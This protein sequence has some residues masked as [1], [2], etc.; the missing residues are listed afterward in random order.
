MMNSRIREF[1]G[2]L[3]V[4]VLSVEAGVRPADVEKLL[5]EL[6][7]TAGRLTEEDVAGRLNLPR[8]SVSLLDYGRVVGGAGPAGDG[9]RSIWETLV[10]DFLSGRKRDLGHADLVALA[11]IMDE[12]GVFASQVAAALGEDPDPAAMAGVGDLLRH[13][14]AFLVDTLGIDPREALATVKRCLLELPGKIGLGVAEVGLGEG[15]TART[16]TET[17]RSFSLEDTARF[18]ASTLDAGTSARR[19]LTNVLQLISLDDSARRDILPMLRQRMEQQVEGGLSEEKWRQIQRFMSPSSERYVSDSYGRLLDLAVTAEDGEGPIDGDDGERSE[20]LTSL[21]PDSV[22]EDLFWLLIEDARITLDDRLFEVLR[23]EVGG[24]LGGFVAEGLTAPAASG[25]R[26][27]RQAVEGDD[28]HP[29]RRSALA[30]LAAESLTPG[31]LEKLLEKMPGGDSGAAEGEVR[32]ILLAAPAA[33]AAVGVSVLAAADDETLPRFL[34]EVLAD[35]GAP[36]AAEALRLLPEAR[37]PGLRRLLKLLGAVGEAAAVPRLAPLLRHGDQ[38]VRLDA[39][40]ALVSIDAAA[41]PDL[42]MGVVDDGDD[43]MVELIAAYLAARGDQA[44]IVGRLLARA[45]KTGLF[46]G[47]DATA[48]SA[49]A[50]LGTIGAQEAVPLLRKLLLR[51]RPLMPSAR[52]HD[53]ALAAVAALGSIAGPEAESALRDGARKGAKQVARACSLALKRRGGGSR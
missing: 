12:S 45:G 19:R 25:I 32:D 28:L 3:G 2:R 9:E 16:V 26:A 48:R 37:G 43:E 8:L 21:E 1:L 18:L 14:R 6:A 15:E 38:G 13:G 35:I 27:L 11:S 51:R 39:A 24:L 44:R 33:A 52:R 20:F 23:R 36:A 7:V 46:G 49:V 47:H 5:N 34:H 30:S 41:V 50:A 42:L 40:R 4:A 29:E 53:L 10:G 22:R 31:I 17:L